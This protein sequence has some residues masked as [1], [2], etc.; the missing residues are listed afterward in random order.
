MTVEMADQ[1]GHDVEMIAMTGRFL[2]LLRLLEMAVQWLIRCGNCKTWIMSI[3]VTRKTAN[4]LMLIP[5]GIMFALN[6]MLLV[7]AWMTPEAEQR[8]W[9]FISSGLGLAGCVW[10]TRLVL[11][12]RSRY[13]DES[14]E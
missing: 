14:G 4:T 10:L 8:V 9:I 12:E 11:K 13:E 5:I 2:D 6:V 3:K 7:Y 1:V